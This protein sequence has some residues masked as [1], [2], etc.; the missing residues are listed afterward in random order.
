MKLA[1]TE[2]SLD[3]ENFLKLSSAYEA[4]MATDAAKGLDILPLADFVAKIKQS[5]PQSTGTRRSE[6]AFSDTILL[7]ARYG[8]SA[9]VSTGVDA[10]DTNPDVMVVQVS[11]PYRIGLPSKER[12]EDGALVK[13]YENAV[14]EV[15]SLLT[16]DADQSAAAG[17]VALEKKLAAA[18]P[19][20]EERQDVKVSDGDLPGDA[21]TDSMQKYYNPMS[22]KEAS[23][24][25][26]KV[27][28]ASVI[29]GLA[30]GKEVDRL[31]MAT[32]NYMKKLQPILEEFDDAVLQSYFVWKAVQ[33]LYSYIE[34]PVVKPYKAFVNE[35]AGKVCHCLA[36]PPIPVPPSLPSEASN[37]Y[38][39]ILWFAIRIYELQ[40]TEN[41]VRIPTLFRKDGVPASTTSTVVSAGSYL[42]ST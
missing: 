35:L 9:F 2:R 36:N 24:L 16:P 7:L 40:L 31:I 11:A 41:I 38:S 8:I 30:S 12:Y 23:G 32:P 34:S 6:N 33:S 25:A 4:C 29:Y 10:D 20:N 39:H 14:V 5:F 21:K 42:A 13:K 18:S 27:D 26:P 15:L 28:L 37:A 1:A 22:L 3:E 19:S 17:V